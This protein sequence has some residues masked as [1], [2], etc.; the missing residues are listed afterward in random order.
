RG[1]ARRLAAALAPL[2]AAALLT[3]RDRLSLRLLLR[4]LPGGG[5]GLDRRGLRLVGSDAG[6]GARLLASLATAAAAAALGSCGICCG[7]RARFGGG[8]LDYERLGSSLDKRCSGRSRR[9]VG[10]ILPSTE[11]GQAKTPS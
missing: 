9:D 3:L 11:P 2:R 5:V 1:A 7:G 10:L 4:S 6:R 8:L